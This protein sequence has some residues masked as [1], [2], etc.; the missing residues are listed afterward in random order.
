MPK[1]LVFLTLALLC[2]LATAALAADFVLCEGE[3]Y[4]KQAGTRGPDYK[5]AASGGQVLGLEW[6]THQGDFARWRLHLDSAVSPGALLVR[7]ARQL[8]DSAPFDLA[9]DGPGLHLKRR[10]AFA[11]TGGWGEQ[12]SDFRLLRLD[13]PALAAGDYLLQLTAAAE[14]CNTNIDCLLLGSAAALPR[15]DKEFQAFLARLELEKIQR[16]R[17]FDAPATFELPAFEQVPFASKRFLKQARSS[18]VLS[19][20]ASKPNP[21]LVKGWDTP[22]GTD[23]TGDY[24]WQLAGE[25]NH[26]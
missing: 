10:L 18:R 3:H 14:H 6:G 12:S 26:D 19:C 11:S 20:L 9:L 2:L 8:P 17:R 25:G 24:T 5:S 23:P 4:F 21:Y 16:L 7:Y 13:L 15:T 1:V 22:G